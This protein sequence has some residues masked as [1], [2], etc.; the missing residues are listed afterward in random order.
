MPLAL[1][2]LQKKLCMAEKGRVPGLI[3]LQK[4]HDAVIIHEVSLPLHILV[5]EILKKPNYLR[6]LTLTVDD[7]TIHQTQ[8]TKKAA[9]WCSVRRLAG[10]N[11]LT[12]HHFASHTHNLASWSPILLP[13]TLMHKT[14]RNDLLS[15]LIS[16]SSTPQLLWMHPVQNFY[17]ICPGSV[18]RCLLSRRE[19]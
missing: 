12:L 9:K 5:H 7:I 15:L 13:T 11:R 1:L 2:F 6:R 4:L 18:E 19:R 8:P 16:E 3:A 10:A 17:R 14:P